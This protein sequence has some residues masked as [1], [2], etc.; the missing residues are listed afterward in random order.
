MMGVGRDISER[1]RGEEQLRFLSSI[2]ENTSDAIIVTD[3][4]FAITYIN[5][6]GETVFWLHPG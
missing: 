4:N 6:V 2:T 5:K 1:K 3:T